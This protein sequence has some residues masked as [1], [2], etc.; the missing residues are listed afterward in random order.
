MRGIEATS[1]CLAFSYGHAGFL[2]IG[3]ALGVGS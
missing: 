1:I 3:A 2:A